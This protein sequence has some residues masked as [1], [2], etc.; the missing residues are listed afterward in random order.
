M[1]GKVFVAIFVPT[2]SP[3]LCL[4]VETMKRL[5]ILVFI[6]ALL[7]SRGVFNAFR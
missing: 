2:K 1:G 6:A 7:V 3:Q 4:K 5:V